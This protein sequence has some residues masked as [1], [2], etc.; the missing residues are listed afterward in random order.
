MVYYMAQACVFEG[1]GGAAKLWISPV[2]TKKSFDVARFRAQFPRTGPV[3]VFD[4]KA[5]GDTLPEQV[6]GGVFAREV[7]YFKDA[8]DFF[9]WLDAP[10]PPAT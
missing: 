8:T 4:P 10:C 3:S 7:E 6:L 1:D 2:F 5:W 9:A